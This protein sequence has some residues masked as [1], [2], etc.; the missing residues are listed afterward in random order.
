MI[1][2]ILRRIF[3]I[4]PTLLGILVVNF[5]I[6][7]AAPGGPVEK[8]IAQIKGNEVS[9]TERFS[10]SG[11]E[12]TNSAQN[13]IQSNF[14]D[15]KYRGSQGIDPD[16][17]K[18]LEKQYGFDKP[19]YQRFFLMLKNYVMFDFGESFYKDKKVIELIKEKLPVS[20]SL[21]LWTTLIIYLISIPLGIK[22]AVKDGSEFDIYTSSL[23][24]IGY[25]IPGFLFAIFLIVLFAGGSY[26]DFFPLRGLVSDNWSELSTLNK[27]KDYFWH[28]AL[29][30]LAMVIGGFASLTMLTKNAFL[31]EINKQYVITARAKGIS[32][33]KVLYGHVFRNAMLI[34][35]S[36]FPAAF[37][38]ILFTSSL[39]IEVI[40]S[41][42]GLG[43]LGF[44]A[45]LG[46]DYP[47]VFGS[48]Y[49]FTLIGLIL[50]LISDLTYVLIDPRIDFD[51]R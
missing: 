41:L 45:A 27:I 4:I 25:A 39:L 16:L 10:S 15:S 12:Q 14:N 22:K 37:I 5:L 43:L 44:E 49:I 42:D 32:E 13:K 19:A 21:G 26:F 28:L 51:E 50:K 34:V 36:G 40:F 18:E 29:P 1:N 31:D 9:V 48:L 24:I 23:V 38:N 30:I 35:I 46:R 7:Q 6:I 3:L 33:K 20:I 17:I 11:G 2:Y 47:V 8:V